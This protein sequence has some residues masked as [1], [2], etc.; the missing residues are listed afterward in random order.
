MVG[1][2]WG[3]SYTKWSVSV[4]DG[5][6][7]DTKGLCGRLHPDMERKQ[8]SCFPYPILNW[9]QGTENAEEEYKT[10]EA[11]VHPFL[12]PAATQRRANRHKKE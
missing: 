5:R 1:S 10:P 2:L 7:M 8:W 3:G 6:K 11:K 4:N 12:A 9:K